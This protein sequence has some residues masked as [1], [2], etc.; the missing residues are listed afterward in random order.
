MKT[1]IMANVMETVIEYDEG[2]LNY[3]QEQ[4]T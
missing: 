3:F 4:M 2:L 1:Y